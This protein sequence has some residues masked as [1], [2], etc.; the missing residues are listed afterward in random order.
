MVFDEGSKKSLFGGN[1]EEGGGG[2]ARGGCKGNNSYLLENISRNCCHGAASQNAIKKQMNWN[3]IAT[4]E[5]RGCMRVGVG[6][7]VRVC[8]CVEV[9]L[10]VEVL[11][12][13]CRFVDTVCCWVCVCVRVGCCCASSSRK[14]TT[15]KRSRRRN[16]KKVLRKVERQ[17]VKMN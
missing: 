9:Y 17:C 14:K 4:V 5:L 10:Q 13:L 3:D 7:R 16:S 1:V 12:S 11:D 2:W 8:V 6:V 15:E